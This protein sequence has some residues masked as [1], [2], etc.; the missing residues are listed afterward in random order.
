VRADPKTYGLRPRLWLLMRFYNHR[1]CILQLGCFIT[2]CCENNLACLVWPSWEMLF[3][4]KSSVKKP[5][6]FLLEIHPKSSEGVSYKGVSLIFFCCIYFII[7]THLWYNNTINW[8]CLF[9]S[10]KDFYSGF[11]GSVHNSEWECAWSGE[12]NK[13]ASAL[14]ISNNKKYWCWQ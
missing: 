8:F 5:V 9:T 4:R 12:T 10:L 1:H 13:K 3:L 6:A 11:S 7:K 2:E 14:I